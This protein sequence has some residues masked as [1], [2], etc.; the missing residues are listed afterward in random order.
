[1]PMDLV[2]LGNMI[3]D[4]VVFAD[5][6]TRLAQP[7]GASLYVALGAAVWGARAAIVA[8]IGDDYPRETLAALG[9]KGID[10]S[11]LRPL[12]RAGL[13]TWLRYEPEGRRLEHQASSPTHIE[14][15]PTPEDL[16]AVPIDA[17][18][19]HI[20]PIPVVCQARLIESLAA[21][22]ECHL[23][24]DPHDPLREGT[25]A[26]WGPL[27]AAIDMLFV[28]EE[29]IALPG[30]DRDPAA[31]LAS[32]AGGRLRS[33]AL[34]QGARGGVHVDIA[35]HHA[36]RWPART[37]EVIEPTGAGDA[38]AGGFLAGHLAGLDAVDALVRGVVSASFALEGWGAERLFTAT[39][40]E[41]RARF[42]AWRN[43]FLE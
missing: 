21:R 20:A 23:S 41:A 18:A 13:R 26:Q 4:D 22:R 31:V 39:G 28:S 36:T 9:A 19:F 30:L 14:A 15:S 2:C 34:K 7:G 8:P 42:D 24:I 10:L 35:T 3:V 32:L 1:M 11:A 29:E 12:Q 38:F 5:G 25:L 33:I 17:R 37:I 16:A 6:T 27:L 40:E 43:G